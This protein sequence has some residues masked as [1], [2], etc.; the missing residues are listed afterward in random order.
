MPPSVRTNTT[1]FSAQTVPIN[2]WSHLAAT[3][4]GT[5][6]RIYLNGM[7]VTN[8]TYAGGIFAGNLNLGLGIIPPSPLFSGSAN[9][10][11]G[12]LDEVSLYQRALS[13]VGADLEF[14]EIGRELASA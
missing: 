8:R 9:P 3:Y 7:M 14:Y 13:D 1:L 12:L 5:T 11:T 4:D 6:M 2:Q 10:F